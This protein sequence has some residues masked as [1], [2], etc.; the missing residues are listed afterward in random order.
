MGNDTSKILKNKLNTD[1]SEKSKPKLSEKTIEYICNETN[2]TRSYIEELVENFFDETNKD[3][4]DKKD[5]KRL[6]CS[7]RAEP[8]E[9]LS[10]IADFVFSA[11]DRDRDEHLSLE[12]FIV[13]IFLLFISINRSLIIKNVFYSK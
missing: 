5:F 1:K 3:Y 7:L 4:L 8:E 9:K 6:Y 2:Q 10:K 12:D 13:C 11:F